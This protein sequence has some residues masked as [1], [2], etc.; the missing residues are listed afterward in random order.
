[1]VFGNIGS[2]YLNENIPNYPLKG[3]EVKDPNQIMVELFSEKELQMV[4][5]D[6]N[7]FIKKRKFRNKIHLFNSQQ[8]EFD[9]DK[10]AQIRGKLIKE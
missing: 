8:D 5:E 4:S 9:E 3:C 2:T 6:P 1:M 10:D 7:Y